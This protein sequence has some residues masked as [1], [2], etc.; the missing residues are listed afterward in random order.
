MPSDQPD[1]HTAF[2][3]RLE[4]SEAEP[5][6]D[7]DDYYIWGADVIED[8]DGRFH[9]FAARWPHGAPEEHGAW[10][11]H[12]EIVRA[13][14]DDPTGPFEVRETVVEPFAH[15]PEIIDT[16][17][18]YLLYYLGPGGQTYL[19]VA[20]D[21]TGP[22][23]HHETGISAPSNP[24]AA[25]RPDG[26]IVL[27]IKQSD[28]DLTRRYDA[29]VAEDYRGPYELVNEQVFDRED[30]EGPTEDM[31]I[32]RDGGLYHMVSNWGPRAGFS[33]TEGFHALSKDGVS[34]D[35]PE[36]AAAFTLD[37]P[38]SDGSRM[39]LTDEGRL[40]RVKVFARDGV[41]THM[42]HAA[43]PV[44]KSEI[45]PETS[46]WSLVTPLR[47]PVALSVEGDGD[48]TEPPALE[49][50]ADTVSVRIQDASLDP[51]SLRF[52]SV[53]A[54]NA[55]DGATPASVEVTATGIRAEF[56]TADLGYDETAIDYAAK[57]VGSTESGDVASGYLAV[58]VDKS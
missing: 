36:E 53:D 41:P 6:L 46:S 26:S 19:R 47:E 7:Q 31:T 8:E 17:E 34:W 39:D 21:P 5:A 57:L 23:E 35:V 4:P 2:I 33:E 9:M 10:Q 18:V 50:D 32:W 1:G 37:R 52:G 16:G 54:V 42:Y 27:I 29:Y 22:W 48:A 12:S 49:T 55:G 58:Q 14:A 51:A 15:N 28:D 11:T 40:E 25:V 3:D 44:D 24:A 45:T 38:L 43:T 20:E 13:V 56:P 30:P